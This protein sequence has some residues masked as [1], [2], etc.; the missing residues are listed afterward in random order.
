MK[1]IVWLLSSLLAGASAYAD[2]CTDVFTHGAATFSP[3]GTITFDQGAQ[4]LG[5]DGILDFIS[6]D[7]Q[8]GGVSCGTSACAISGNTA[9]NLT[10]ESYRFSSSDDD[11]TVGNGNNLTLSAGEYKTLQVESRGAITFDTVGGT[12]VIDQLQLKDSTRVNFAPGDYW[13][14]DL[15]MEQGATLTVSGNAT[16]RIYVQS[17]QFKRNT[18]IND[19]GAPDNLVI[20]S[21]DDI[22]LEDRAAV[23]GYVYALGDL[24]LTN[25]ARVIGAVSAANVDLGQNT[26][27]SFIET[28]IGAADF[29]AVCEAPPEQT[30]PEL[31]AHWP[32]DVCSLTGD[33]G[34]V[35][36]VING[37]NG[38]SVDGANIDVQGQYCQAGDFAGSG[39][40]I[41]IPH[42][43]VFALA[44]GTVSLWFRA[45][46][47]S[48]SNDRR[49]GGMGLFSKD[50]TGTDNGGDHL[51]IWLDSDGGL[52]VRHQST[53]SSFEIDTSAGIVSADTW[54][55]LVY[56][57][58]TGGMALYLDAQPVGTNTYTGGLSGNPEPIILASNAW[59]TDNNV[60]PSNQLGDHFRGQLDDVRLY[61]AAMDVT[62]IQTL[63]ALAAGTCDECVFEDVLEAHWPMDICSVNGSSNEIVDIV[64][65]YSGSTVDN[66]GIEQSGKFCQAGDFNGTGA[67][68][69]IPAQSA[70][71]ASEG[72]VSLWFNTSDIDHSHASRH[73]GQGLV[74]RDSTGFDGGGHLTIWLQANGSLKVRHQDS[75]Q[76]YEITTASAATENTWHHM[77][78]TWGRSGMQLYL[79]NQQIGS[80]SNFT[81][82]LNGNQEPLILAA[83]AW[84]SGDNQANPNDLGD[85]F[86]G[87]IDDVRFFSNQINTSTIDGLFNQ[88]EG[89]CA[90]CDSVDL[91]AHYQFEQTQWTGFG[92][93]LDSSAFMRHGSPLG[94]VSSA[95]VTEAVSCRV[96]DVP[97]NTAEGI[98][99]AVDTGIDMNTV[100][101]QGTISFWYR[102]NEPWSDSV[103][104]QLFDASNDGLASDK[105]FYLALDDGELEFGIE[106][107]DDRGI[108]VNLTDLTFAADEWV[109]I[110]V[111]WDLPGEE[112][113][114]YVSND[115][116]SL[117]ASGTRSGLNDALGD[118]LSL[119]IGDNRGTYRIEE[120]TV[121]SANGQFDDFRIYNSVQTA[122]EIGDDK[123]SVNTCTSVD[124]Y[125]ITFNSPGLTCEASTFEVQACV[126][127]ACTEFYDQP[128]SIN[129]SGIGDISI[130][131]GADT[132]SGQ[133]A[134]SSPGDFAF[135][136][137]S[138]N[139]ETINNPPITCNDDTDC[140]LAFE[141]AAL[142]VY[143]VST[144][145]SPEDQVAEAAFSAVQIRAVRNNSGVCEAAVE[146]NQTLTLSYSCSDAQSQ[147]TSALNYG[148]AA[149]SSG[150]PISLNFNSDGQ[151]VLSDGA[152]AASDLTLN[153][154][155]ELNLSA[156]MTV[157][158]AQLSTGGTTRITVYPASLALELD[159]GAEFV[160]GDNFTLTLSA[161][162]AIGDTPLPSYQP[163]ELEINAYRS[164]N[165]TEAGTLTYGA[166]VTKQS[167]DASGFTRE[168]NTPV[169][170]DGLYTYAN[171][172]Y[173]EEGSLNL[174]FRDTYAGNVIES[175]E[176][177]VSFRP[178][179]LLVTDVT[180]PTFLP[181]CGSVQSSN[182]F[183]YIGRN[184][185]F[186]TNPEFTV[187]AYN[188]GGDITENYQ[189][190]DWS[191]LSGSGQLNEVNY[192]NSTYPP[193]VTLNSAG[194]IELGLLDAQDA[195][196]KGTAVVSLLNAK[197]QYN[198]DAAVLPAPLA[199]PE[200]A[201]ST[202]FFQNG[203]LCAVD[204]ANPGGGCVGMSFG[205]IGGGEHRFG[206]LTLQNN[207]GSDNVDMKIGVIIEYFNGSAFE[208]NTL[209]NCTTLNFG[210]ADFAL[211][212]VGDGSDI[213]ALLR[214][215][216][217]ANFTFVNGR[218]PAFAGVIVP[219]APDPD[220]PNQ[221][222]GGQFLL[223]LLPI[224]ETNADWQHLS[225]PWG[226]PNGNNLPLSVIVFGQFRGNDR[227]I[228]WREVVG[229]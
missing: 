45:P 111:T 23:T 148:G 80:N 204:S 207:T 28:D 144:G 206:R 107:A 185:T 156:A 15:Q 196:L 39:Q 103:S 171:S 31:V 159:G 78:Y 106:D 112:L 60:S 20:V 153:D 10:L 164:G 101:N 125:N 126:D 58:G 136:L 141:D 84:Q 137:V 118:M 209:D 132:G 222:I 158:D 65:G 168:F 123:E 193:G 64:N 76:S 163:L 197:M 150:D 41:N 56:T 77:V 195:P 202:A 221:G 25:G 62:E 139:P 182:A 199:G 36:D 52:F 3:S 140:T 2:Q 14:K 161:R 110:A 216:V 32:F 97:L 131:A 72:A 169:F 200:M 186:D 73:G 44:E 47:L 19:R 225:Y 7:D 167:S 113:R 16:V 172:T 188:R 35:L 34:E 119:Y 228:N 74:S 38:S 201:L 147:C 192:V 109:H 198:R 220:N 133:V 27:V 223:E 26:R 203:N 51:T 179:Y 82:G 183:S 117:S 79:D 205:N 96:L 155:A 218:N 116:V 21:Y 143:G 6:I 105:H 68:I 40:H 67:H 217:T 99:D 151:A 176:L 190:G 95:S 12:Y 59:Q 102:S 43:S 219:F 30:E 212:H 104:R 57:F 128:S 29:A 66:A 177:A 129:L 166:A 13:I 122:Q 50:S 17:A 170:S 157:D 75:S 187:T 70:F 46:N 160:A 85:F 152:G 114:L 138:S 69:N 120:S 98:V 33:A 184:L 210:Q 53:A 115:A 135:S 83:N 175:A 22:Q 211:T 4:V 214:D 1:R 181:F 92:D 226:N 61:D 5:T 215:D 90:S 227:I 48:H 146:G 54:H 87:Q 224:A 173:D 55:H 208:P 100:G 94:G 174:A 189:S 154:V 89:T 91:Q 49:R 142:Q 145:L 93:V 9:G 42:S 149:L 37:I 8:S 88:A 213:T 180:E 108:F 124:H 81:G 134:Q 86:R 162:G 194:S 11:R 178:A 121:N 18:E 127:A 165:D 63:N 71:E 130:P 191:W 24:Q 229:D